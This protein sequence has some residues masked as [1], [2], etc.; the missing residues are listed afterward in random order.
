MDGVKALLL[1]VA[2]RVEYSNNYRTTF[3]TLATRYLVSRSIQC[4]K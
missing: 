3:N 2:K 1:D 4:S